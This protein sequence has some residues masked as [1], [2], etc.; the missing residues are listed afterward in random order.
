MT[1][2]VVGLLE[3]KVAARL[4]LADKAPAAIDLLVPACVALM[5]A[6]LPEV[7]WSVPTVPLVVVPCEDRTVDSQLVELRLA[8]VGPPLVLSVFLRPGVITRP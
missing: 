7:V 3:T 8:H 1:F 6:P 5:V 4:I 2:M